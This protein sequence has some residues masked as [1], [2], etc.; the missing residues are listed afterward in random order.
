MKKAYQPVTFSGE[1]LLRGE[2]RLFNRYDFR[3]LSGLEFSWRVEADG[4]VIATA[5]WM[6]P[7]LDARSDAVVPVPLPKISVRP[8]AEYFLTVEAR[9]R[10]AD[11]L[12]PKGHVVAWEQFQLPL[13]APRDRSLGHRADRLQVVDAGADLAV[14]GRGFDVRFEKASGALVS[15]KSDRR[16]LLV[17][18]LQP[19]FWRAPTDNDIGAKLPEQVKIWKTMPGTAVLRSFTHKPQPDGAIVVRAQSSMANG[20]VDFAVD[21]RVDPD[22]SVRVSV[23]FDP[24]DLDL[25][26]LPRLGMQFAS[27]G[28]RF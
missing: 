7:A 19:H 13:H 10:V 20:R 26:L 27:P 17:D 28:A 25:P 22:G 18:K 11:G 1:P 23:S 3:D 21:Y 4:R 8:G 12:V 6:V 2:L 24:H 9:A 15:L 5:P 16:E 14:S